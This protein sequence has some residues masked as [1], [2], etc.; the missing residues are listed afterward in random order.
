MKPVHAGGIQK[1]VAADPHGARP[2]GLGGAKIKKRR[3]F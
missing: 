3:A 2:G 1:P